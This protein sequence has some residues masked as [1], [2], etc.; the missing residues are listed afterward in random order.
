MRRRNSEQVGEVIR[1]ILRMEGLEAPLNQY[2]LVDAWKDV[3]GQGI[4]NYTQQI[5][6]KNQTLFVH[7]T[8]PVLRQEL[9]MTRQIL[10]RRL[11]EKAGAQVITD[12]VFR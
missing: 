5:Y 2:R 11:N 6:V 9:M 1:K 7:L 4:A 8:S 12:I 3:V 10:V